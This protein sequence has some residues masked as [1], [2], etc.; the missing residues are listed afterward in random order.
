MPSPGRLGVAVLSLRPASCPGPRCEDW[1]P[2][3]MTGAFRLMLGMLVGAAQFGG[4]GR[5]PPSAGGPWKLT[6]GGAATPGAELPG[7]GPGGEDL[8]VI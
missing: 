7:G 8:L 6:P 3:R 5:G 1:V 2:R 4:K